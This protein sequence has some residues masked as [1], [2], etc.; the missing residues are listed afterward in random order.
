MNTYNRAHA[1]AQA[2]KESLQLKKYQEA[3]AKLD[4]DP[5][6]KEML[7]DFRKAQLELQKQQMSG[8]EISE[9]QKE[10]VSKLYEVINLNLVV[11]EYLEA[12]NQLLVMVQDIYKIIGEPLSDVLGP[13]LS[14]FEETGES[15]NK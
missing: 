13:E 4:E 15:E 10:R 11:K 6:A 14:P 5:S 7:T 3:K 2:L 1:L 12:E 8:V 9:E